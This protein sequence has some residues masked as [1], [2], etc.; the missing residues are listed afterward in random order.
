VRIEPRFEIFSGSNDKDAMWI[1]TV[2]GLADARSRMEQLALQVP[3]KFF[4]FSCYSH[5]ILA[6]IDTSENYVRAGQTTKTREV[7]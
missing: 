2:T 6:H 5:T 1:E 7:A 3:G 4:I